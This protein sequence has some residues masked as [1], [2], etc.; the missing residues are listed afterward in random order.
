M[1]LVMKSFWKPATR[2]GS[3]LPVHSVGFVV[4]D[5]PVLAATLT[6]IADAPRLASAPCRGISTRWYMYWPTSVS[7]LPCWP[8]A[9]QLWLACGVPTMMLQSLPPGSRQ[10]LLFGLG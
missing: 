7:L 9:E 1:Y 4:S 3:A 10:L 8:T 6:V 2:G 5:E